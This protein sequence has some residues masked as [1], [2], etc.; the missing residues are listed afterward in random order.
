[1]ADDLFA[2]T[3]RPGADYDAHSIE[4]LEG[5]EPVRR[6]PGM[7]VGGTDERALHHLAAEVLDNA[8]TR[9]SPATPRRIEVDARGRATRLTIADNGR[10]IPVDE[11]PKYPGQVRARGDPHHAPFGREI[12]GQGLCDL[13]RPARRRRQ[14][15][16]RAVVGHDGRGRARQAALSP[17]LR[18]RPADLAADRAGRDPEPARHH[19]RLHPRRRDFRR[20]REVQA[21]PA[22]PAGALQ[23]LSVRRRRDPLEMR[24]RA[25]RRRD[26][27]PRRC[28]S[29]PA[30]S[31]TICKEQIG[32]RETRDQRAL[33]R[34]AGFPERPGLGRMGGRLAALGRRQRLL[35]LQHHPDPRRRHPR[36]GPADGADPRHP[37]VRRAG[38]PEEGQGHP[39]RGRRSPAP[40]SC[41]RCSS[42]IPSSRARPRTG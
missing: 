9:R 37:R 19:H 16:Q 26:A 8:W 11:H 6:R 1:M 18:A 3:A 38:R 23:G 24:P 35:L 21:G 12:L 25:D 2:S 10:G 28:S 5:L 39:G 20:G 14:R 33:H 41:S 13:G 32:D 22:L 34:P 15:R 36:A 31:P 17:E 29:S 7:Y 4:V 27:R 42:A 30:A 40:R